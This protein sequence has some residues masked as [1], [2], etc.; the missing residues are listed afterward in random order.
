[1][2]APGPGIPSQAAFRGSA[3]KRSSA[4]R[5][6]KSSTAFWPCCLAC[7]IRAATSAGDDTRALPTETI[8]SPAVRPFFAAQLSA[9]TPVTTTPA[10]SSPI[11]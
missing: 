10:M 7:L 9:A 5:L 4:S 2:A 11:P 6:I 1:M 8:T 3:T